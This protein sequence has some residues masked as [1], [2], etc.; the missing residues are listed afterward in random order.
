MWN[1]SDSVFCW[2]VFLFSTIFQLYCGGHYYWWRKTGV[3]GE[4]HRPTASRWQPLSHNIVSSIPPLSGILIHTIEHVSPQVCKVH[5]PGG[6]PYEAFDNTGNNSVR[7]IFWPQMFYHRHELVDQRHF[8]QYF[9][10]IVV[11]IIIGGGKLECPEKTTDL[12]QV[13]DKL[14]YIILYQVYLLLIIFV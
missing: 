2:V 11:V 4:N 3:S 13:A 5:F 9:S 12:P 14:C 1:C 6:F 10:Y 8:Q 7:H